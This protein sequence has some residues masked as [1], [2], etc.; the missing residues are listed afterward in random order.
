L[1]EPTTGREKCRR[2]SIKAD[3]FTR[4]TPAEPARRGK[5]TFRRCVSSEKTIGS[6]KERRTLYKCPGKRTRGGD[7]NNR[8]IPSKIKKSVQSNRRPGGIVKGKQSQTLTKKK[9]KVGGGKKK[10]KENRD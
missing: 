8:P 10:K 4:K 3:P 6:P 1:R 7:G 2:K 9:K 5:L